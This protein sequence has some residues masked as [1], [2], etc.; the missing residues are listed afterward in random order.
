MKSEWLRALTGGA[1]LGAASVLLLWGNGRIAGVSGIAGVALRLKGGDLAWRLLFLG[2]LALAGLLAVALGHV[3]FDVAALP[4]G[5]G[6][7]VA[8]LAVGLGTRYANGCT[9]GHGICG[10]SR[11]S[12]RSMV[13]T[14][15]FMAAAAGT[16]FAV[17]HLGQ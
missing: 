5:G 8:G 7:V 17:R 1:L 12:L 9:S 3:Q 16:V 10:I 6:L 2:G 4:S 14:G 15:T 11:G 13:A